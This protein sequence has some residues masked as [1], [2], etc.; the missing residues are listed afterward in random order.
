MDGH[1]FIL[2]GLPGDDH[3]FADIGDNHDPK[4]FTVCHR[5][6]AE[7]AVCIDIGANIGVKTLYLS[8]H[9]NRGRVIAVEAGKKNSECLLANVEAN[10]LK[11]VEVLNAAI[12][13]RTGEVR[14][15]EHFAF[16]HV[17]A[18]GATVPM[19]TID[20]LARQFSLDRIDFIKVDVEGYEYPI[21]KSSLALI[22]RHR[23]LI[24]FEFNSWCQVAISD[25][26]PKEF[27]SWLVD[28][29]AYLFLV[30]LSRK[31]SM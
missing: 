20:D 10:G 18:E 22:N 1:E 17:S 5:F 29:F 26:N 7:D 27:M 11:N 3:Y 14:F 23:S 9:A 24:Y 19:L 30:L 16:G 21:L 6:V 15:H 25:T 8:R 31:K 13:D 28:N 4:F 12:G 2:H